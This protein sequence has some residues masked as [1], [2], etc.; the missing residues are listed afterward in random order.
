MIPR[1]LSILLTMYQ[2]QGHSY[3]FVFLNQ[4]VPMTKKELFLFHREP[5]Q[6]DDPTTHLTS[7]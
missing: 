6:T 5:N 7:K 2:L 3:H 4:T 1:V